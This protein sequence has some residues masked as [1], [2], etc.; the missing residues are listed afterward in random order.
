MAEGHSAGQLILQLHDK[1]VTVDELGDNQKSV[2]FE[3]IAVSFIL[4]TTWSVFM[5]D[6]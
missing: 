3:K 6:L 5:F 2:I 4:V 1:F